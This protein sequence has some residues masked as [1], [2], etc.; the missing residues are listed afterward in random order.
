MTPEQALKKW[1]RDPFYT[2]K[3]VVGLDIGIQGI[4]VCIRKGSRIVFARTYLVSLPESAPLQGRRLKRAMRRSRASLRHR[5][6]LY[7]LWCK[8]FNIPLVEGD[9]K[10]RTNAWTLRLRAATRGVASAEAISVCLRHILGR[11]GFSYHRDNDDVLQPWG[12]STDYSTVKRWID[13][14]CFDQ[15]FATEVLRKLNDYEWM[16]K[17]GKNTEKGEEICQKVTERV[18]Y[19]ES[20]PLLNHIEKHLKAPFHLRQKAW[21]VNFPRDL[22]EQHAHEII[23]KHEKIFGGKTR[24]EEAYQAYLK[25][26]NYARKEPGALAERKVKRC[27]Y[28]EK[29]NPE[30]LSKKK[31]FCAKA[32]NFEVRHLN[33]VEFLALRGAID[34]IGDK[35]KANHQFY[36][37]CLEHLKQDTEAIKNKSKRPKLGKELRD[38]FEEAL[39]IKCAKNKDCS[40]NE[41]FFDQLKDLLSPRLSSL[42]GRASCS[43][44]AAKIL[45]SRALT[46]GWDN[47]NLIESWAEFF[48]ARRDLEKGYGLAPQVEFLLGRTSK[49]GKKQA[50]DGLLRR[51]FTELQ[52]E[53]GT[54][55][56]DY[57]VA[58]VIRD[59]PRNKEEAKERDKSLKHSKEYLDQ[60]FE[61]YGLE[62]GGNRTQRT[63]IEL[64]EQQNGLCPYTGE[65]LK[66]PLN[67]ALQVDHIY[68]REMG[69]TSQRIN[70]V[71]TT[72]HTNK[73]K[74]KR[75]PFQA[76]SDFPN[77]E[78]SIKRMKWPQAKRD[79]FLRKELT[80][81]DWQNLTRTSQL[82]RELRDQIARWLGIKGQPDQIRKRIGSPSGLQ[83]AQCRR[84]SSWKA[85]LPE[86]DNKKDRENQR[87]HL[88]DAIVLSHIPPADGL[89]TVH[90]G[91]IFYPV[92]PEE[93]GSL[94]WEAIDVGPD[95]NAFEAETK[96]L[97]LVV[98][99]RPRKSKQARTE[100]SIYGMREDGRLIIRKSLLTGQ[101]LVQK[102]AEKWI[103]GSGIPSAFIPKKK[104]EDFL[105]QDKDAKPL[106]LS[107]GTRVDSVPTL[108]P[109]ESLMA[110]LPH[111]N[112]EG[113]I[114]GW[115]IMGSPYSRME[116]WLAP[117]L[118][119]KG[120][121][122]FQKRFVPNPRGMASWH[123]LAK[124]GKRIWWGKK[125]N[126]DGENISDRRRVIGEAMK[127]FSKKFCTVKIGDF[128]RT[129][130]D[131]LGNV[132]TPT[133]DKES[134]SFA[135]KAASEWVW[136]RITQMGSSGQVGT[137]IAEKP[138]N[139][140]I[141]ETNPSNPSAIA[142][143]RFFAL[144]AE[145]DIKSLALVSSATNQLNKNRAKR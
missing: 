38:K 125:N 127:P 28:F 144:Q 124:D 76:L 78:V 30:T 134:N 112:K 72:A 100:E 9:A 67:P 91:G 53:L 84:S 51:I 39:K 22:I 62:E 29:L 95:I 130:Y 77:L 2:D 122:V 126:K 121:P 88:W 57:V 75:T 131:V 145:K 111:K 56:P 14:A 96:D 140:V 107:N 46:N 118:D 33:L 12:E 59:A 40:P 25:I 132:L 63:R 110:L 101:K 58:E 90:N 103:A 17:E 138:K 21:D 102:D 13:S 89:Q 32:D 47:L 108:A 115:K 105:N 66:N 113:E 123:R 137:R 20:T 94:G 93:P 52:G 19:Y 36:E 114:I 50:T 37:F 65:E 70:L 120:N 49:D 81:P 1:Q 139:N 104:L 74:S 6:F 42:A 43:E 16:M 5:D 44:Q 128:L 133:W 129:P 85:K 27:P 24:A 23:H 142:A 48:N 135:C 141:K 60:L 64:F 69:G 79:L 41:H 31:P 54:I 83:T 55:T 92:A 136:L 71:L 18:S 99:H 8:E 109:Q 15:N 86:V 117:E 45:L 143:F 68:P 87:H 3:V 61:R 73:L 7:K 106:I 4:G 11:R 26:L 82:A 80:I 10:A 34:V 116:I 119:K 97:C 98:K 35:H